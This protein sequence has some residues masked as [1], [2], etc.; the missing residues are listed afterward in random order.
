MRSRSYVK[1]CDQPS[2]SNATYVCDDLNDDV[3][4]TH[5][6]GEKYR[7]RVF[8]LRY[9]DLCIEPYQTVNRLL[10]FLDLPRRP[11]I[12]NEY[13]EILTGTSRYVHTF[14]HDFFIFDKNFVKSTYSVYTMMMV[15][16]E[17]LIVE[18]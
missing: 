4:N 12:M 14:N 1:W 10:K 11:D 15:S 16:R 9:E 6:L 18:F 13:I 3:E 7:N 2:C 8:L 17:I 5:L